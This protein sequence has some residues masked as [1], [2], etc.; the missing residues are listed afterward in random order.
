MLIR[1][2]LTLPL[3]LGAF[4]LGAAD[5]SGKWSGSIEVV[6]DGQSRTVSVLLILKQ[7]GTKLNGTA[8][9][10]E[11]DQHAITKATVDGDKVRLEI[12][13]GDVTFYLDLKVDGDQM[14]GEA[15]RG[16][17]PRMKISVKRVKGD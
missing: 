12:D 8:G 5:L 11:N 13:G 15:R 10:D 3:F 1:L 6:E 4:G 9:G 2:L 14:T 16:D 7:D 17:D